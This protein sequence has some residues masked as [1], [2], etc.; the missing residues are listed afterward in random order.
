MAVGPECSEVGNGPNLG[1]LLG[2]E[3]VQMLAANRGVEWWGSSHLLQHDE[4][5][6]EE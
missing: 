2:G 3:L 5:Q 4:S 1:D 6:G